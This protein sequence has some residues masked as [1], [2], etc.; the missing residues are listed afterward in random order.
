MSASPAWKVYTRDGEY[1]ASVKHPTLGAMIC[2]GLGEGTTI[3]L[4]HRRIVWT[5][6]EDGQS[7]DSYDMVAE[8]CLGGAQ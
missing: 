2:A 4:G 6:G 7:S 3:R 1:V 8:R 5:E